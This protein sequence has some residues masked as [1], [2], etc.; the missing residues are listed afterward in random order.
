MRSVPCS[1][2]DRGAQLRLVETVRRD[3]CARTM[4]PR[5]TAS[6]ASHS[7]ASSPRSLELT[8]APPPRAAKSRIKRVDLRLGGDVDALRR[9]VEQQHGDL[10]RQPFRQDHLLLIAAGQAPTP[11]APAA[12]DGCRASSI[13]SVTMRSPA[14]AVEPAACAQ[15]TI[16]TGQ[17]DIVADRLVHDEAEPRVRPAPCQCPR[18]S[19]SR[20]TCSRS[21]RRHASRPAPALSDA[22]QA[23]Q[24]PI[25][26]AAEQ[27]RRAP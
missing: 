20:G 13:S 2:A 25:R 18:R 26:A 12:A 6:T 10:A 5:R 27:A 21:L 14:L 23:P 22:E 24:H 1:P 9:L 19:A 7:R 15:S 4:R 8:S 3:R 17:Q 16:E 11:A